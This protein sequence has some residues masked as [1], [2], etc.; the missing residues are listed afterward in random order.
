MA[1]SFHQ[2]LIPSDVGGSHADESEETGRVLVERIYRPYGLLP[3]R[4]DSNNRESSAEA[5]GL[6]EEPPNGFSSSGKPTN[7]FKR[8]STLTME[9][10]EKN[11]NLCNF[12]EHK[13]EIIK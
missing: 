4:N 12:S 3:L 11:E 7:A 8:D 9:Q 5:R 6:P 10:A 2:P 1:D 13:I